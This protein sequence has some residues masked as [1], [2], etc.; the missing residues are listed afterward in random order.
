[1]ETGKILKTTISNAEDDTIALLTGYGE[2][3]GNDSDK[4][5]FRPMRKLESW[6]NPQATKAVE[7]YNHGREMTLDQV[8]LALF[9]TVII[10]EPTTYEEAINSEQ[11]EDQIKWKNAIDKEF[12]ETEKRVVW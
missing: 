11:K 9:F 10:K 2:D 6:F 7:V 1:M 5:V 4:R 12:K 8:N 3:E